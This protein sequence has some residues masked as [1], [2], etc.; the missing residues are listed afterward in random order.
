MKLSKLI[1]TTLAAAAVIGFAGCKGDDDDPNDMINGSNKVYT[2]NY[3]NISSEIS[4]GYKDTYYKHAGAAVQLDFTD[5]TAATAKAGV[6]GLIF[7][8]ETVDK[9]TNRRNFNVVGVRTKDANGNLEYYISR[10]ENVTNIQA[11]NFGASTTATGDDAKE[12]VYKKTWNDAVGENS[13]GTTTVYVYAIEKKMNLAGTDSADVSYEAG[14]YVYKVYLLNN[15]VAKLDADGNLVD[16]NGQTVDLSDTTELATIAV[17][18]KL[19][20]DGTRETSAPTAPIQRRLAVYANVYPTADNHPDAPNGCGTL[21][22][23]WTYRGDYKY[24]GVEE[25]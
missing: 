23:K 21:N 3:T 6:M 20:S 25:D 7:D 2:I 4:R 5:L 1:L 8:L 18:R 19:K 15:K 10:F 11:G 13:N 14:D 22:G 12:I 9:A 17:P 16:E 24:V